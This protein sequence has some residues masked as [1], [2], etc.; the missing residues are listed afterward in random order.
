VI[1]EI[2]SGKPVGTLFLP[3]GQTVQ[4]RKR[5]IGFAA[6]PRGKMHLDAGARLAIE[7]QGRSLLPVGIV[8][9]EGKFTKGDVVSLRGPAQG[10]GDDRRDHPARQG[11]ACGRNQG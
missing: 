6:Q 3:Q 1:N 4:S 8:K 10:R 5:W 9:I 11:L 2:L 7:N